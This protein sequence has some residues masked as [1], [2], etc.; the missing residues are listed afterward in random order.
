MVRM[1]SDGASPWLKY[2]RHPPKSLKNSV[3]KMNLNNALSLVYDAYEKKIKEDA[4]DDINGNERQTLP[5]YIQD[6][7]M[8][9]FGL[10]SLSEGYL[11]SLVGTITKLASSSRRLHRFGIM[12]GVIEGDHYSPRVRI[13]RPRRQRATEGD[14]G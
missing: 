7:A 12:V 11:Y 4:F 8:Q 9:K 14:R 13:Q 2:M 3:K 1:E 10:P 6:F 5:E